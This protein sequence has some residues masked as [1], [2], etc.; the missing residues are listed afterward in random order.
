MKDHHL[1]DLQG[2]SS[3]K[4][5]CCYNCQREYE[6]CKNG[7]ISS[8]VSA[9]QYSGAEVSKQLKI[10][11]KL[12]ADC[13]LTFCSDCSR[14]HTHHLNKIT[15]P[16]PRFAWRSYL[17]LRSR[18]PLLGSWGLLHFGSEQQ[19]A[20]L[21]LLLWGTP[22]GRTRWSLADRWAAAGA[23][24][25]PRADGTY[26]CSRRWGWTE[27]FCAERSPGIFFVPDSE[28]N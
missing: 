5:C 8:G 6:P 3:G 19:R 11:L 17:H 10:C 25:R 23:C 15:H 27:P 13:A 26:R 16:N 1:S 18:P 28:A 22:Q 12:L 9:S 2:N 24:A 7:K 14:G 20:G 4:T 21:H